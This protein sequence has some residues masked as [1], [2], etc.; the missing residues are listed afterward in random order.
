MAF[1]VTMRTTLADTI[2]KYIADHPKEWHHSAQLERMTFQYHR[3]DKLVNA[4]PG[5]IGRTLRLLEEKRLIAVTYP[6]GT[7]QYRYIP[8]DWR[9]KYI[10]ISQR[11]GEKIWLL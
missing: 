2:L 11:K 9:A 8:K 1:L 3:R 10:P 6:N 5:T 4:K 7:A